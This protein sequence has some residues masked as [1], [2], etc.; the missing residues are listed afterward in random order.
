MPKL[1]LSAEAILVAAHNSLSAV[2]DCQHTVPA[3]W[4]TTSAHRRSALMWP[5][6]AKAKERGRPAEISGSR[7][8]TLPS[9]CPTTGITAIRN[10]GG[11]TPW[12]N[13]FKPRPKQDGESK[14]A[15]PVRTG[16]QFTRSAET[17]IFSDTVT[18]FKWDYLM[19]ISLVIYVGL[20]KPLSHSQRLLQ[21]L[22]AWKF[23][24]GKAF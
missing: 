6:P 12:N 13:N 3:S 15:H 17:R 10:K 22:S 4:D 5:Q 9:P 7:Q 2:S 16:E 11:N 23:D 20:D 18:S 19:G 8:H 1:V 14:Q 24:T 21:Q